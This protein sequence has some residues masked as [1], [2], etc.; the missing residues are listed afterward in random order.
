MEKDEVRTNDSLCWQAFGV[1]DAHGRRVQP[2]SRKWQYALR[3]T[4][5]E[6]EHEEQRQHLR[7]QQRRRRNERES[8]AF[9]FFFFL[10]KTQ[11]SDLPACQGERQFRQKRFCLARA[12]STFLKSTLNHMHQCVLTPVCDWSFAC[13]SG[14]RL[15]C[16]ADTNNRITCHCRKK[17]TNFH[18]CVWI[19]VGRGMR[20]GVLDLWKEFGSISKV[21]VRSELTLPVHLFYVVTRFRSLLS[22]SGL[23]MSVISLDYGVVRMREMRVWCGMMHKR[24]LR[25][26][27]AWRPHV[28]PREQQSVVHSVMDKSTIV[29]AISDGLVALSPRR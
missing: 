5:K 23:S 9:G 10:K 25:E 15:V 20:A 3:Q 13:V 22:G 14:Q 28:A 11:T 24:V 16:V 8:T 7:Q 29:L 1:G 26:Q 17:E 19:S 27:C 2:S 4:V 6:A 18:E 12:W 21:M